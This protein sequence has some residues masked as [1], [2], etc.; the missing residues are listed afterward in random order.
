MEQEGKP[1]FKEIKGRLGAR[2]CV[3]ESVCGRPGAGAHNSLKYDGESSGLL[4]TISSM[5]PSTPEEAETRGQEQLS[6]PLSGGMGCVHLCTCSLIVLSSY[7][8]KGS[9]ASI[10]LWAPPSPLLPTWPWLPRTPS[11]PH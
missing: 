8:L 3:C 1:D 11:H 9:M 7:H 2:L 5:S 10:L 6:T 4:Y